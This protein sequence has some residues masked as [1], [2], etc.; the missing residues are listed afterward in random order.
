MS[1]AMTWTNTIERDS[2]RR[3]G[4]TEQMIC[5][6]FDA[7]LAERRRVTADPTTGPACAVIIVGADKKH[8]DELRRRVNDLIERWYLNS[9]RNRMEMWVNGRPVDTELC[10]IAGAFG[11]HFVAVGEPAAY[12]QWHPRPHVFVDHHAVD[13]IVYLTLMRTGIV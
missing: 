3:A 9:S 12:H 6:A 13:R 7:A 8:V 4:R 2:Y 1:G 10:P 11:I 5:D